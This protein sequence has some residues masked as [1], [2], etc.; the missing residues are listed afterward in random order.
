MTLQIVDKALS[1]LQVGV[2]EIQKN[3]RVAHYERSRTKRFSQNPRL[4]RKLPLAEIHGAKAVETE[5]D[6][7][8]YGFAA[9]GVFGNAG[10]VSER[11]GQPMLT[12]FYTLALASGAVLIMAAIAKLIP[13]KLWKK[14]FNAFRIDE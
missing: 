9:I 5:R 11:G 14:I 1:K 4:F 3:A 13:E 12:I 2:Y 6:V 8:N 7:Q 10:S